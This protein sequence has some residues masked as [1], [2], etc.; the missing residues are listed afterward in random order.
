MPTGHLKT[1]T[2]ATLAAGALVLGA[3]GSDSDTSTA[4]SSSSAPTRTVDDSAVE[5]GIKQ[6]LSTSSSDVTSVKCPSDVKVQKGGTFTCTATWSNGATGKVKVTQQGAN[7]YTYAP[8][9]GSV[10]IPGASVEKELQAQL[11]KEGAPNA[12]VNCPDNIIVKV[13]SPVTCDV[14][15]G[16]GKVGGSVTFTFSN[17]EGD[18]DSSSVSTG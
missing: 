9:S 12:A 11:A 3:C 5:S 16:G 10:Q 13:D 18:I 2:M 4:E 6:Q 15:G 14:S 7:H 17:A 8:V 1:I